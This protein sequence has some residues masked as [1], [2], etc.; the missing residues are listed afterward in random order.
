MINMQSKGKGNII[1]IRL[2]PDED[3]NTEL[4]KACKKHNVKTAI[5]ISGIG[6]LKEAELGYFKKRGDYSPDTISA[7]HEILSLTGNICKNKDEHLLHLHIILGDEKK[8]AVGGHFINGQVSI[9]AE[10]VLLKTNVDIKRKYDE[11]T[12]LQ[13]LFLE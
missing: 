8:N 1:F 5:I 2:F 9:T 4:K 7:S 13:A 11:E 12:G 3:V 10:I 6:Q